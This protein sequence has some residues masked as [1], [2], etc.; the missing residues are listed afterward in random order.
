MNQGKIRRWRRG[1]GADESLYEEEGNPVDDLFGCGFDGDVMTG[2]GD[3][4]RT[5]L[6]FP[7]ISGIDLPIFGASDKAQVLSGFDMCSANCD[8]L[9][10]EI[11]LPKDSLDEPLEY[12]STNFCLVSTLLRVPA[13]KSKD[14]FLHGVDSVMKF[15]F[16]EQSKDKVV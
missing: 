6:K 13:F 1:G 4:E 16:K 3:I 10:C 12:E 8:N 9:L 5:D 7:L 11:M 15:L 14:A 2:W